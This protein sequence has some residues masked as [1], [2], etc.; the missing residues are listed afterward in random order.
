MKFTSRGVPVLSDQDIESTA[1]QLLNDVEPSCLIAPSRTPIPI[2][3]QHLKDEYGLKVS[4]TDSLGF[5]NERKIRGKT[6]LSQGIIFIDEE[7]VYNDE[8]L[9]YMTA[10][11]EIGHWTL[12]RHKK[13]TRSKDNE[14]IDFFEDNEYSF[15]DSNALSLVTK[16]KELISEIDWLEHHAKVFAASLLMP[17]VAFINA[18]IALQNSWGINRNIGKVSLYSDK[19]LNQDFYQ[20]VHTLQ[21]I[22]GVSQQAVTIRIKEL[23]LMK[24]YREKPPKSVTETLR[25][26]SLRLDRDS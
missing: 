25:A 16:I 6:V 23:N 3:L 13:I 17:R 26:F 5:I 2:I 18:L 12:H 8:P 21:D 9:Y 1:Y 22:F 10:A 24:D 4:I 20:M 19:H 11:H 14:N 7:I 15:W